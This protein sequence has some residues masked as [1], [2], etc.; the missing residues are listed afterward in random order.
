MATVTQTAPQGDFVVLPMGEYAG[1]VKSVTP[2]SSVFDGKSSPNLKFVFVLIE[3]DDG[4]GKPVELWGWTSQ[5]FSQHEKCKLMGWV[6]AIFNK[7]SIPDEYNLDTDD[8]LGR[9]VMV[10]VQKYQDGDGNDKNKVLGLA[11]HPDGEVVEVAATE[12]ED[13]PF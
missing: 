3:T 13:L 10:Q 7:N 8:L 4:D 2:G 1:Y 12:E 6:K 11:P 9:P 5:I